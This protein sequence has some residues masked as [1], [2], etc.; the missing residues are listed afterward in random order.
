MNYEGVGGVGGVGG[1]G[2]V[3]GLGGVVGLGRNRR[4]RGSRYLKGSMW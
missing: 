2:E 3:S 1:Q 4:R